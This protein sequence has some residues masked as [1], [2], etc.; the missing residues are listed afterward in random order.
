MA[1][2]SE[3]L[4]SSLREIVK[5]IAL[6]LKEKRESVSVTETVCLHFNNLSDLLHS[7]LAGTSLKSAKKPTGSR[8][9]DI[10]ISFGI[11]RRELLLQGRAYGKFI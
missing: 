10:R 5:E 9:T 2:A 4:P 11:P 3:F 1:S 6:L 7:E 8:R